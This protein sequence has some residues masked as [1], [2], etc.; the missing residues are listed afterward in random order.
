MATRVNLSVVRPALIFACNVAPTYVIVILF[1]FAISNSG[2]KTGFKITEMGLFATDPDAGEIM[3]VALTDDIPDYMP[4]E[5]GSTV[6][7]QE[8]Q[9]QFTMSNT[10]SVSAIINPNG[11]LTVAHN[12]DEAAH[13]NILMVT[14]TANKPATMSDRGLWVELVE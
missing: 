12:T 3:Y 10:G 4:A 2:V 8:F 6:V 14:P 13:E 1:Q 9:L 5:G 11:F 7:Q